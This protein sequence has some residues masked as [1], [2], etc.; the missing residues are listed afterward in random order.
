MRDF[1]RDHSALALNTATLGHN[2]E[3]TWRRLG[4]GTGH[5]C[6]RRARRRCDCLLAPRDRRTGSRD[7]ERPAPRAWRSAGSAAPRS[8]SGRWLR[9]GDRRLSTISKLS[10]DMAADLGAEVLTSV[11]GGVD[12]GSTRDDA[13]A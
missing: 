6:L 11:V 12:P 8:W 9:Q 4:T 5:R 1:S 7:R 3:G 2:L 13:R 10:I